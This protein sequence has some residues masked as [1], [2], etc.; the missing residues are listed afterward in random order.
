MVASPF[1]FKSARA[2]QPLHVAAKLTRGH[3][4]GTTIRVFGRMPAVVVQ[5][6]FKLSSLPTYLKKPLTIAQRRD[7]RE[8]LA[9]IESVDAL[10][11]DIYAYPGRTFGQLYRQFFL[12][13]ELT[14]GT[15]TL[16]ERVV[17]LADVRVP[18]MNVAGASDVL[19]PRASVHAVRELLPNAPQLRLETAPGGHLGV[20][21][22][23]KARETTWRHAEDFFAEHAA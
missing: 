20:L 6:L 14:G 3:V 18:V 13:N 19:A 21:A 2:L 9:H 1:D 17:D 22:G 7:D 12:A 8:F 11:S 4:S 23:I 10:M 5:N 15:L 16:G